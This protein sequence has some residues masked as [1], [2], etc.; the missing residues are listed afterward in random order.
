MSGIDAL[1]AISQN[2]AIF[3][4]SDH[5]DFAG[6]YN[7]V[8]KWCTGLDDIMT[9]VPLI[10]RVPGGSRGHVVNAPVQSFDLFYTLT[11]MAKVW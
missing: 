3:V 9:R 11:V 8:E 1:P 2:T 6:D 7:L 4:T 10:A 5:G